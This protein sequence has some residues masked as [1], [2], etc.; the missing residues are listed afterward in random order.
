ML[1]MGGKKIPAHCWTTLPFFLNLILVPQTVLLPLVQLMIHVFFL[2]SQISCS[3]A[4]HSD[5]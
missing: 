5:P 3:A 2:L 1:Q 4:L